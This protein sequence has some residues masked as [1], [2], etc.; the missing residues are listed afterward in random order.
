MK[1]IILILTILISTSAH[2]IDGIETINGFEDN[3]LPVLNEQFRKID[4]KTKDLDSQVDTNTTAIGALVIPAAA[5]QTLM[6]AAA[7]TTTYVAPGTAQNHPGVAKAWCI[8]DGTDTG[9]HAC[10]AGYNV[11]SVT[12]NGT[13][14]YTITWATDFSSANYAVVATVQ[15][16]TAQLIV[17]HLKASSLAVGTA[18]FEV[19]NGVDASAVDPPV[20]M[21]AAYGDQ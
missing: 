2:A 18:D 14:D 16:I 5:S 17:V 10:D 8:F 3:D 6:E 19:K 12:R 4:D 11:A 13:G 7:S 20:F 9:T 21:L 1:K 15:D